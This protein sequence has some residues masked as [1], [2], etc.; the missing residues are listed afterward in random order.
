MINAK[1]YKYNQFTMTYDAPNQTAEPADRPTPGGYWTQSNS[2]PSTWFWTPTSYGDEGLYER[3]RAAA[4]CAAQDR[5]DA[6]ENGE[7]DY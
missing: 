1:G 6:Y 2:K 4:A 5:K 7:G 3:S